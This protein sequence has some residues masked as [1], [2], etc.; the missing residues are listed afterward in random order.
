VV[1]FM[2]E[3]GVNVEVGTGSFAFGGGASVVSSAEWG[4]PWGM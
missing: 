4:L 3:V 2:E 1:T